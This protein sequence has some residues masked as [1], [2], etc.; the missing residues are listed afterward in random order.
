[1]AELNITSQTVE[2]IYH[3]WE[4]KNKKEKKRGYL[5]ASELGKPCSRELW[6]NFRWCTEKNFDGR[7]LRLFNRGQREEDVFIEE[8]RGIGCEVWDRDPDTGEQ[9]SIKF[10]NGHGG[11]HCDGIIKG[12]PEAPKTPHI[13]EFKTINKKLFFELEKKGVREKYPVYYSQMQIY[14]NYFGLK[15]A[16]F[17]AA[18]KDDDRLYAERVYFSKEDA[19]ALEDRGNMIIAA[20]EPPVRLSERADWYQCKYCDAWDVCHGGKIPAPNCRNCVFATPIEDGQWKCECKLAEVGI[21]NEFTD[22][23]VYHLYIPHILGTPENSDGDSWIT[24]IRPDGSTCCNCNAVGFPGA[25]R[26]DGEWLLSSDI[27]QNQFKEVEKVPEL[28][29][30]EQKIKKPWEK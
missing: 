10:C 15:R 24:T 12:L 29:L 6:Y 22:D 5:G 28:T 16:L 26:P 13:G 17:L 3:F 19:Q 21:I 8:L 9:F 27:Y 7:I 14:M 30:V 20:K 23:C 2:A 4:D 18:C 25:D 11:G 1:M